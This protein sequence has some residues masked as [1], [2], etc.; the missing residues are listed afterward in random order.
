MTDWTVS[1]EERSNTTKIGSEYKIYMNLKIKNY[2]V[3]V[4][5]VLESTM[6]GMYFL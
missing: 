2:L 3:L 4:I 1:F 5:K 6:A